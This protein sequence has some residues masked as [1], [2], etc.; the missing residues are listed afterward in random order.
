MQ[1]RTVQADSAN[2][3][4]KILKVKAASTAPPHS[5]RNYVTV[6]DELV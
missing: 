6:F 1:I 4:E 3:S 5:L 2:R